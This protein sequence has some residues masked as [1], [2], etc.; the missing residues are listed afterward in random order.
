MG[1]APLLCTFLQT[2][3]LPWKL[4]SGLPVSYFPLLPTWLYVADLAKPVW[5]HIIQTGRY[6]SC[7]LGRGAD[8][9]GSLTALH[10]ISILWESHHETPCMNV[11][12][13]TL[14]RWC[15]EWLHWNNPSHPFGFRQRLRNFSNINKIVSIA[16]KK[17]TYYTIMGCLFHAAQTGIT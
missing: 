11:W 12:I 17:L 7:S 4:K 2:L 1:F 16:Q 15:V 3:F 8:S 5:E 14:N 6:D 13:S 10:W 9:C